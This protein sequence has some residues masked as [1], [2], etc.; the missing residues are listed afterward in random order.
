[1]AGF[2]LAGGNEMPVFDLVNGT[3]DMPS[4]S[5]ILKDATITSVGNGWYR[6]SMMFSYSGSSSFSITL[7]N[8]ATDNS[9]SGYAYTG[10]GSNG[11]YIQDAQLEQGLVATDYIE[12]GDKRSAVRYLG[13][14]A[15]P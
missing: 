8:S 13:G 14:Y 11:F 4:T 6:C 15:S 3:I 12:T 2:G 5:S 10:T 7:C 1:M 9:L